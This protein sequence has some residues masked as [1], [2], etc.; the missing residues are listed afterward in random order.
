M[1]DITFKL[2]NN[3]GEEVVEKS[4]E[5]E[6]FEC[7]VIPFGDNIYIPI[8][9]CFETNTVTCVPA[10]KINLDEENGGKTKTDST[11]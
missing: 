6:N 4:I 1:P 2:F 3:S 8:F 11:K 5:V 7:V 9:H 10:E